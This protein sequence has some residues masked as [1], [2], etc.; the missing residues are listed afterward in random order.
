[1]T[2]SAQVHHC[3]DQQDVP[4]VPP[5]SEEELRAKYERVKHRLLPK[6]DNMTE[7]EQQLRILR[8]LLSFTFPSETYLGEQS[9]A[10]IRIIGSC[11]HDYMLH[12]I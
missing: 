5:E 12:I 7:S 2:T 4:P 3:F 11:R 10:N 8:G 1:M 9:S 6:S